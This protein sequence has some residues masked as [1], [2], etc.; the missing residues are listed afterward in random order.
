LAAPDAVP[1]GKSTLELPFE[2][3]T[4]KVYTYKPANFQN[5]PM[6][7][8]FHGILRNAEEYRDHAVDMGDRFGALIVCPLFEEKIFPIPK[9]QFG[10]IVD[11][12][13]RAVPAKD[14]T[15]EYVNRIAKE[16]RRREGRSEMPYALIGH[17]GGGQ[18][19]GRL[20]A[21]VQTDAQ[22]IVVS[23]PSSYTLPTDK[24]PFPFGFGGLPAELQNDEV[25]KAYL[26]QPV[27]LYVGSKDIVR[28]EYFDAS[29]L[30]EVQGKTRFERAKY[31]YEFAKKVAQEKGWPF[32]W[33]LLIAEGIEHDHE[34]MFN[35]PDCAIALGW[36]PKEAKAP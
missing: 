9:Y 2:K 5:G 11:D 6:L 30:A 14:R 23:N 12:E 1:E 3:L 27:T 34:K 16:I 36:K 7:M 35:S 13:G 21:F 32:N 17:S 31:A 18:F 10:G 25:Y 24:Q 22:R 20:A 29:P 26:G 19:L 33:K 8:V 15:A 28:D 4:L